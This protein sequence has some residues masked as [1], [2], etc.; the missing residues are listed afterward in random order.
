M[1]TAG[2]RWRM[3]RLLASLHGSRSTELVARKNMSFLPQ[4]CFCD[5]SFFERRAKRSHDEEKRTENLRHRLAF[6]RSF[7]TEEK[8]RSAKEEASAPRKTRT[9]GL[10]KKNGNNKKRA[11]TTGETK[12]GPEK[13]E[14]PEENDD[15]V[16]SRK[17]EK[18][19]G[20][21]TRSLYKQVC[22]TLRDGMSESVRRGVSG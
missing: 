9:A 3:S 10:D 13:G 2:D 1:V 7:A 16:E 20:R 14:R 22:W 5:L 4:A 21:V 19:K 15:F 8:S 12:Q 18:Q 17:S 11:G 6:V